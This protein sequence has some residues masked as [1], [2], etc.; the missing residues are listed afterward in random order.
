[1]KHINENLREHILKTPLSDT[2]SHI[3]DTNPVDALNLLVGGY[4]IADLRNAGY[5]Y[6]DLHTMWNSK[7]SFEERGP[8]A[9]AAF[10]KIELTGFSEGHRILMT[11]FIGIEDFSAASLHKA[12]DFINE[13]ANPAGAYHLMHNVANIHHT[14]SDIL[15]KN[16]KD[17]LPD[18]GR[19]NP[20]FFHCD[21]SWWNFS[22]GII[23]VEQIAQNSD[24]TVTSIETLKQAMVEICRRFAPFAIAIKSQHGYQRTLCWQERSDAEADMALQRVLKDEADRADR[25]C[26]GDWCWA[27]GVEFAI[28]YDL[29][30]KLHTGHNDG[31]DFMQQENGR[32]SNLCDIVRRYPECNF[33]ML[34]CAWPFLDETVSM[35]KHYTNVYGEMSWMWGLNP[36]AGRNFLRQVIHGLPYNKVFAYGSDTGIFHACSMAMHARKHITIALSEEI[37]DGYISEQQGLDIATAIMLGNQQ[38]FFPLDRVNSNRAAA[39]QQMAVLA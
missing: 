13:N 10:K 24:I 21:L 31:N 5:S 26:L 2:H 25:I 1:M 23:N 15:T 20:D 11:D 36:P 30:M 27:R 7:L 38:A 12:Q 16:P 9:E 28:E 4:A 14:Q 34:H 33:M 8:M 39:Y 29:P 22:N 19:D 35:L 18:Y 6:D 3:N 32:P 37:N 17:V